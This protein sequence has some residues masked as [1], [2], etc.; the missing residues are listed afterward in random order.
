MDFGNCAKTVKDKKISLVENKS[1]LILNNEKLREITKVQ[2]DGCLPIDGV[3]CDWLIIVVEPPVEIYV[4][5]KGSDVKHAF[6]Q[7]ENTIKHI[8]KDKTKK[9]KFCYVITTR[10]PLSSPEIQQKA[11]YFKKN[12]NATLRV[13]KTICTESLD[14]L[15]V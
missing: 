9:I 7:L 15:I 10:V 3:K 6:E 2:V 11:K 8:S 14:S 13:R 12:Y 5:L 4:E 1:K